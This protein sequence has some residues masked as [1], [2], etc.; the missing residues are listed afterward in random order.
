MGRLSVEQLGRPADEVLERTRHSVVAHAYGMSPG[1]RRDHDGSTVYFEYN[2]AWLA[3]F[4][5]SPSNAGRAVEI[6]PDMLSW[7]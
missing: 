1:R 4:G 3:V 5:I 2:P 7:R 6:S